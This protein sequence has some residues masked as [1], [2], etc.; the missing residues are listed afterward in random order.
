MFKQRVKNNIQ[1]CNTC[2]D[3][4]KIR[5]M[6]NDYGI[7]KF[8]LE[9]DIFENYHIKTNNNIFAKMIVGECDEEKA[10]QFKHIDENFILITSPENNSH[11]LLTPKTLE[12]ETFN[13][14]TLGEKHISLLKRMKEIA[15]FY[16]EEN[17]IEK[18]GLFF[19]CYPFNSINTLH[20][21]IVN[22]SIEPDF[23]YNRN[24]LL[25]DN[26]IS[27]LENNISYLKWKI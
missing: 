21:H 19:H 25:L 11:K 6:L 3:Y 7:E 5:N 13:I 17:N 12:W 9:S 20:L 8:Y 14:L 22:L 27:V 1:K 4:I 23:Q 10:K 15:L 2:R 16:I 24:N 26:V 18:Y